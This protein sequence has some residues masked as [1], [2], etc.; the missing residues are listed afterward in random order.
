MQYV[1]TQD[2]LMDTLDEELDPWTPLYIYRHR[3]RQ[4]GRKNKLE[5]KVGWKDSE[6]TWENADAVH[7]QAPYIALDYIKRNKLQNHRLF[8][9]VNQILPEVEATIRKAFAAAVGDGPKYKFGELV[10]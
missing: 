4:V 6:P 7:L 2:V 9:W 10:P 3:Q 1:I 8:S 5:Y